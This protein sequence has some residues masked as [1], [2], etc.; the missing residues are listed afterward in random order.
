MSMTSLSLCDSQKDQG[1]TL[2]SAGTVVLRIIRLV[3]TQERIGAS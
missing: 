3:K 2:A 1:Q